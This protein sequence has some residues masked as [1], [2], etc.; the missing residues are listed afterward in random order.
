MNIMS[1]AVKAMQ[2]AMIDSVQQLCTSFIS[3]ILHGNKEGTCT[4]DNV[5]LIH[6]FT[7]HVHASYTHDMEH[8][9]QEG[10]EKREKREKKEKKEKNKN[11]KKEGK[12]GRRGRRGRRRRRG[13]R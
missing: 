13:R 5:Q 6:S 2:E 10:R 4:T 7:H 3:I 9:V 1:Q 11:N 12:R 8:V